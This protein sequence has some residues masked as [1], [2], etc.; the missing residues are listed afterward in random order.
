[1]SHNRFFPG[2]DLIDIDTG[3]LE[4]NTILFRFSGVI[5]DPCHVQQGL[6]GDTPAMEANTARVG[7]GIDQ[8]DTHAKISGKKCRGITAGTGTDYGKLRVVPVFH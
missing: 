7:F 1:L 6:G 5:H 2:T 3:F 4:R 8:R